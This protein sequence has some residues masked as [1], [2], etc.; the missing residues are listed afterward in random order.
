[1]S[2]HN[3]ILPDANLYICITQSVLGHISMNIFISPTTETQVM[4]LT[5]KELP[6][7]M[8]AVLLPLIVDS[9][10]STLDQDLYVQFERAVKA[11]RSVNFLLCCPSHECHMFYV[12]LGPDFHC[13]LRGESVNHN[14]HASGHSEPLAH[15]NS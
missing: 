11:L 6:V 10:A 8:H 15:C 14:S 7:L 9:L 1:M 3:F 12:S 13:V 2:A 4:P 5:T